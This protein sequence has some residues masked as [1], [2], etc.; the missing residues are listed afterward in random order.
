MIS[1]TGI[2]T[3]RNHSSMYRIIAFLKIDGGELG[4]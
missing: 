4:K 1:S 3:P 2:G